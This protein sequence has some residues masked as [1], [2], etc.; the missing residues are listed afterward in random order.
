MSRIAVF[1]GDDAS[2]EV[3]RSAVQIVDKAG[4]DIEW[5]HATADD[6]A[7]MRD[8]IDNSDATLFGSASAR[9]VPAIEYLRWGKKTYANVRPITTMP[10]AATPLAD[11]SGI[12]FAIV[13]ENLEDLYV[14][15]EG[16]LADLSGAGLTDRIGR[17]IG[18]HGA[19]TFAVK[20]VTTSGIEQVARSAFEL[21][22]TRAHQRSRTG[23]V[24]IGTKHNVLPVTDGHFREVALDVATEY[25][26]V[27]VVSYLADDLARRL[28]ISP[29]E[30]DVVL[31][32]NLYGDILSDEAAALVGGLGV[33]PSGCY[34]ADYAYFEAS[35]GTAPDIAGKN[36]INPT[37]Q[38]LA[39][40][41]MLDYLG[42]D[43][44]A[45]RVRSAVHSV[46]A[47]GSCLTVDV[48]GHAS[49]TDFTDAVVA[50]L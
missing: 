3:V 4:A 10:N 26:D 49:T 29:R 13:R 47:E 48:G 8:A 27:E 5:I 9:S 7:L 34:G 25:P 12:D 28:I 46:Y 6:P 21:A 44:P 32:P 11:S 38:I 41:M 17:P 40:A 31:L 23:R 50:A 33:A 20:L 1:E 22:R 30:L 37:A 24:T 16:S 36:I 45:R 15:I 42:Q 39:A 43:D 14:G 18:D 35:H 2:P 19:G